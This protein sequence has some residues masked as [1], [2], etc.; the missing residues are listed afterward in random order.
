MA[1]PARK[2]ECFSH[3]QYKER[4]KPPSRVVVVCVCLHRYQ[5]LR[6]DLRE[7]HAQLKESN[8]RAERSS[9]L[10]RRHQ[11]DLAMRPS[12]EDMLALEAALSRSQYQL[13]LQ[14]GHTD[15]TTAAEA[16]VRVHRTPQL[17]RSTGR[18]QW[19][20]RVLTLM[21]R[22]ACRRRRWRRRFMHRS[23]SWP[24]A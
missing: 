3:A 15:A 12:S 14:A 13:K 18:G 9:K 23:A 17:A 1:Q 2:D 19:R 10:A 8:E 5:R 21:R 16:K 7:A 22:R 4:F 11:A 20:R 24:S 6:Q